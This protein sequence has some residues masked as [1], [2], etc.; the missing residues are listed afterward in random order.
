[1]ELVIL[2][3]ID[4]QANASAYKFSNPSS[5]PDPLSHLSKLDH[6]HGIINDCILEKHEYCLDYSNECGIC[7]LRGFQHCIR[8][9]VYL[10]D[11]KRLVAIK[12]LIDC[13]KR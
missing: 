3:L 13:L 11:P 8:D 4:L 12:C 7:I 6:D 1:M 10:S 2:I 9:S 5:L